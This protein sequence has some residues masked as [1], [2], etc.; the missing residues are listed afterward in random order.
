MIHERRKIRVLKADTDE[1]VYDT[2]YTGPWTLARCELSTPA[3]QTNLVQ[4]PGR[5]GLID[6][7]PG[8]TDGVPRYKQRELTI[9]LECSE[10]DRAYRIGLID[11]IVNL[12]DGYTFRFVLPDDPTRAI[13]GKASVAVDYNDINHCSVTVSAVCDPWR[14]ALDPVLIDLEAESTAKTIVLRNNGRRRAVPILACYDV[15]PAMPDITVT[16]GSF[17]AHLTDYASHQYNA[18]QLDY[19]EERVLSYSG[20][21]HLTFSWRE[22]IL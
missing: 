15:A 11:D 5:D 22:A 9:R 18:L 16:S 21:G 17:T 14:I 4:V 8:L 1:L 2:A 6:L 20:S 13:R 12:L 10:S 19:R 7:M 3:V